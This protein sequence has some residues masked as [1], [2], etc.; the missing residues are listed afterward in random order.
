[1]LKHRALPVVGILALF[2]AG[3]AFG[4]AIRGS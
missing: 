1:M 4:Q 2:G 3:V